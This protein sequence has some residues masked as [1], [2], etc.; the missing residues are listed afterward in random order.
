MILYHLIV[1]SIKSSESMI[2]GKYVIFVILY[3][4]YNMIIFMNIDFKRLLLKLLLEIYLFRILIIEY[5][6][7]TIVIIEWV[8]K[9]VKVLLKA[10]N[11][12]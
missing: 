10:N 6:L 2:K 1:I 5:N 9:C 3:L 7:K 12:Q 8:N 4:F 11:S